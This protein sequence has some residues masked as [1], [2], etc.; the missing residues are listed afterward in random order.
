[1]LA[2]HNLP[3]IERIF[4]Q[5]GT[6]LDNFYVRGLS[7]SAPSWQLL[8]TGRPLEI[9]GNVEYDRYTLRP[10][11]YL[12][13]VPFYFS[14]ATKGRVDMRGVEMLDEIGVPLLLDRFPRD[15]RHQTFQLLQRG[16]RWETLTSSLK[17]LVAKAPG[18]LLDEW[19]IGMSITDTLNKQYEQDLIRALANPKIRYLDYFSGDYDH[20]AH[21]TH[22][23]V[24]QR[25]NLEELDALV[26]R[27]WTAIQKSPLAANTVLVL[28]SDHGMTTTPG[29]MSQGYN[30]V[31]WFSSAAG[32]AHNVLTNRHPLSEFKVKG[33]DPFVSAVVTP[34]T[35]SAYLNGQGATYPTVMLDLDGNERASIGLRNNSFN[36]LQIFLE[37]LTQ[38]RLS[39]ETRASAIDAFFEEL[40]RVRP[41][42]TAD[43]ADLNSLLTGLNTRITEAQAAVAKQPKKWTKQQI[44][45]GLH[46]DAQRAERQLALM[47]EDAR[48]Y[49]SYTATI[50][51]LLALTP[52]DFDPGK[53]KMA[54]LIP[55]R[56]LGPAN[57]VWDLQHYVTGPGP[58]GFLL[59]AN[60]RF[61]W[62]RSF[63]RLNY[64]DALHGLAVRNNVQTEVGPRPVD[65]I[66]LQTPSGIWLYGD[67]QHQALIESDNGKL[68]Y[69]AVANLTGN[70]DGSIRF[71]SQPLGPGFPLAYFEDPNLTVPAAWL[72]DWHTEQEWLAATHRAR[73]SN[74]IVSL[75]AQLEQRPGPNPYQTR[76][77][78]L[79]RTDLLVMAADHWNFN[80]RGFNPGGNHGSF[81]RDSTHSVLMFAGAGIPRGAHIQQPYDSL[82]FAPTILQ[83]LGRPEPDLPGPVIKELLPVKNGD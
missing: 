71:D 81:F 17:R 78:L 25:R 45:Q 74:A 68:R 29:V 10:Y 6:Q 23:P 26:G 16:V 38:R 12:N 11:D 36:T 42:W 41:S 65:F 57:T 83:L 46:K 70:R 47:L 20:V 37:Q 22:D 76:K 13:F 5:G 2:E 62:D 27:I 53:F 69:R 44:A 49:A 40:D 24:S 80:V 82:S 50:A 32:G 35:Q 7:L 30:L 15:Q 72:N 39:P 54:D 3:W 21:L 52:A 77:R 9:H 31:D 67:E 34:T 55:G 33:L 64:L 75:A 63:T 4:V 28:V 60:G 61:D 43:I 1:M 51:R 79:R 14:A 56:S 8:D 59:D 18:E 48:D 73:Y 58:Q 66:A 19:I